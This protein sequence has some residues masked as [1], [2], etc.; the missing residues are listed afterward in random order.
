MR[1]G[2]FA[3]VCF[4]IAVAMGAAVIVTNIVSPL[5]TIGITN[6]LAVGVVAIGIAGL[7]G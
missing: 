4:A 7:Q 2:T 6:L 3:T 1:P 5:S